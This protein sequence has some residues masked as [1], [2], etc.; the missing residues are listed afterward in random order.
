MRTGKIIITDDNE[1]VLKTLRLILA[2]EFKTVV[3]V[4]TPTLLPALLREDDVDVVVLDMNFSSGKQTGGEG[5]FWLDRIRARNNPPEVVLITSFGD[6]ELAVDSL[7]KG[8]ADFIVKPWD[9]EKL[10]ATVIAAWEK[11]RQ[12]KESPQSL[13]IGEQ[14]IIGQLIDF[15]LRKY[16]AAYGKPFPSLD[17]EARDKLE[18]KLLS[19]N[20]L[21]VEQ[22]IERAVLLN[23]SL[24][25]SADDF[26]FDETEAPPSAPLTLEDIEKQFIQTVLQEKKGN[27]TLAAQQLNI[28]RQTL[29][30]KLKKYNL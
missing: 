22:N 28:T 2:R 8:A 26:L 9:N 27:L 3:A 19:G 5:L 17:R 14:P 18:A 12:R 20:I 29:Y 21:F 6:I 4:Q 16:A 11:R 23:N 13:P 25:L 1:N 15:F 24:Q 10:I 30:N 7:K